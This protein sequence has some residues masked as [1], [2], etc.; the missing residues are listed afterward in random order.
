MQKSHTPY[1]GMF[2]HQPR[3]ESAVQDRRCNTAQQSS[4]HQDP[5]VG[6]MLRNTGA[7]VEQTV[8]NTVPPSTTERNSSPLH[9]LPQTSTKDEN[10]N[11]LLIRKA[12]NERSKQ[13]ARSETGDEQQFDFMFRHSI[14]FV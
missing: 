8:Q 4:E 2:E 5:K 6:E 14:A 11:L 10:S 3:L 13:H 1:L 7:A 9:N 12:S